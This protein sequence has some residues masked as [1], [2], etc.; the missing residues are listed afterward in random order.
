MHKL[1]APYS[2]ICFTDVMT[3]TVLS[4]TALGFDGQ[5]IDVECDQTNGL[6]SLQIVGL[7]NKA[8][9]EAKERVRSALRNSGFDMPAKRITINLAPAD[10]PKD[11]A[12]FD[13]P[14]A[15]AVMQSG[16][17]LLAK[18]TAD[19]FF[20]GELALDGSLRP[21][22]GAVHIAEAAKNAGATR[23][24][25][26]EANAG[27]AALISGL[28]VYGF[29]QLKD[30]FL[31]L[32]QQVKTE[33]VQG[34]TLENRSTR[35]SD[36]LI[37]DIKGQLQ[38]KR[39]LLI[40]AAG[41]HNMLMSGP[42]G[43]GKTMLAKAMLSILPP[44]DPDE[45]IEVTKLHSI[46]GNTA[47]VIDGRPFR[48][49]H[50]S[51]S[52]ISIIGG[53]KVPKPGEISLAHR[54][55]LFLDEIPEYSRQSLEAL[56]QPLEDRVVHVARVQGR[57]AFPADF[58]LIATQNPCPCG[59]FGDETRACKCTVAAIE[60]YQQKLS[61]PLLDRIDIIVPLSRVESKDLIDDNKTA[62]STETESFKTAIIKARKQQKQR[63]KSHKLNAST[64]SKDAGLH[65]RIEPSAKQ[66]LNAAADKL[67]LSARAYFKTIKVARTIADLEASDTVAAAH[68]SEAL[69]YRQR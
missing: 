53:G 24:L 47:A 38:A 44:L 6:P 4:A 21:I 48:S 46:S 16:G 64:S 30:V 20:A 14:I 61:G 45:I 35:A 13:L 69:Q 67:Q 19:T 42:P 1:L 49:P 22:R 68:I 12:G 15:I 29:K 34:A 9:D 43:A 33:P 66:F 5:Q 2:N 11:G 60:R 17:Q 63:Y 3:A 56:R 32:K 52:H 51:A 23:L 54:G 65:M 10:L 41:H 55:V 59:Y 37:D 26:P 58:M 7:G 62:H 18:D 39:A 40:A 36:V 31:F 50:H 57:I 27:Q 8:I 25:L 28:E